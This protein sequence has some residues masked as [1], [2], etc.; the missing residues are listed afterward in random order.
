[1]QV[2]I[3]GF[4]D[5]MPEWMTACDMIISKAGPGTIAESFICGLPVLLNG[6]V[7]CQ[8]E[9]NVPF[10][11]KHQVGCILSNG[12]SFQA[13]CVINIEVTKLLHW[14]TPHEARVICDLLPCTAEG[15]PMS[16]PLLLSRSAQGDKSLICLY[17]PLSSG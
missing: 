7:P 10:V 4:V 12:L 17:F 8:E 15:M 3:K 14:C 5:N 9:G 13:L 6:F 1:M 11:L 16:L 2:T